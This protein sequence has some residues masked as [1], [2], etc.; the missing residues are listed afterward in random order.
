MV[1]FVFFRCSFFEHFQW[2]I[3]I[4]VPS[5]LCSLSIFF[6]LFYSTSS[7]YPPNERYEASKMLFC[8]K[9]PTFNIFVEMKAV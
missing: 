4:R 3:S 8:K 6:L 1:V 5:G 2:E 9:M 7:A